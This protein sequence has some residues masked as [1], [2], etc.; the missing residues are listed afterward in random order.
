MIY[1]R[2][3]AADYDH[4]RQ[5][6]LAGWGW[7]DVLPYFQAP[8]GPLP[9]PR[10]TLSRRGRR[11]ARRAAAAA[12]AAARRLPRRP[13]RRPASADRRLQPRRQRRLRLFPRQPEAR[14][15]LVG[16]ERLSQA[17]A[18][19]RQ[20]ARRDRMPRHRP[21]RSTA[22]AR[23]ACA[24]RAGWARAPRRAAAARSSSRPA[25]SARRS[26]C[27]SRASAPARELRDHGIPIVRDLPGVGDNLQDHLQLRAVFKVDRRA[28]AQHAADHR[29]SA[30]GG[31]ALEYAL[32]R[33]GPLTMA[34]SQL[35]A[36]TR[37]DPG[38]SAPTSSS[39]CSRCRSTLRRAAAC[40]PGVHRERLQPAADEPRPACGCARPTRRSRRRSRRTT[41][42]PTS[43]R[44]VAA[45]SLRLSRRIVAQP[46]A[47][48]RFIP[49]EFQ[50]GAAVRRRRRA[51]EGRRRH[52]HD[53]LPPGRHRQMGRASDPAPW[54][55]ALRVSGSPACA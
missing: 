8:R 43:D 22:C 27:S 25:R 3:Q 15:A 33:R 11:M 39:T 14:A 37:S 5:L 54:S 30:A 34:P 35:G 36:F 41:W 29:S 1:M 42:R 13:R 26:C 49:R 20:P 6:G 17:G 31:M 46:R 7:D 44:R 4:W 18:A 52:R 28:H 9:G 53:D 2:G 40:V 10:A 23:A 48:R 24:W 32:L 45:D 19:A 51:R 50:P 55:T 16:G 47:A 38:A 12:L 21:R